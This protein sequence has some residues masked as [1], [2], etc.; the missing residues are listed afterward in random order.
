MC[1][2][3]HSRRRFAAQ[4]V[5]ILPTLNVM[6]HTLVGLFSEELPNSA[7]PLLQDC[8]PEHGTQP[9]LQESQAEREKN[10]TSESMGFYETKLSIE[11]LVSCPAIS[12]P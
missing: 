7:G 6:H 12:I 1:R 9:D 11:I 8:Y 5:V 4:D 10:P 2:V 3:V